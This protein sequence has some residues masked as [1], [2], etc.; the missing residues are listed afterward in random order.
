MVKKQKKD[1][2]NEVEKE[3]EMVNYVDLDHEEETVKFDMNEELC[4]RLYVQGPATRTVTQRMARALKWMGHLNSNQVG[5]KPKRKK[6]WNAYE[7][8]YSDER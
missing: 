3:L 2:S 4:R 1:I 6:G 8:S 7:D 5:T